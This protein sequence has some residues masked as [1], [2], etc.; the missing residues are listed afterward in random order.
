MLIRTIAL[1]CPMLL[2]TA[3]A[4]N[5]DVIYKSIDDKGHPVYA[6]H[7]LSASAQPISI[8]IERDDSA[9]LQTRIN[10]ERSALE[11]SEQTRR[12]KADA[13]RTARAEKEKAERARKENCQRAQSRVR[14]LDNERMVYSFDPQGNRV[15]PSAGE[16]AAQRGNARRDVEQYC[17]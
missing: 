9:D 1:G 15:Y 5:A 11:Q 3:F 6:D 10:A 12:A 8:R 13:D 14:T 16:L 4:S 7:P 17:D 2:L